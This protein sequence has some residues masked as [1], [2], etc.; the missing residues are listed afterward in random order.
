MAA[1]LLLTLEALEPLCLEIY[2]FHNLEYEDENYA[3]KEPAN[4]TSTD[5]ATFNCMRFFHQ[6]VYDFLRTDEMSEF[7]KDKPRNSYGSNL[8]ILKA[9]LA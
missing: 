3:F 8:S 2:S 1:T 6:A 4:L 9:F 7:L 5:L